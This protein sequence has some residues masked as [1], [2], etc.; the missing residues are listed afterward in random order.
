[1]YKTHLYA[2]FA[3]Y[4]KSAY[5]VKK[6]FIAFLGT[7]AGI[8]VSLFLIT[9]GVVIVV[10]VAGASALMGESKAAKI[11]SHSYLELKLEGEITERPGE[12][13]PIAIIQGERTATLGLNEIVG[14]IDAA[15][16]DSKIDAIAI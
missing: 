12:L 9:V 16:S 7:M 1:M 3:E 11:S 15:A 2:I 5:I 6:F 8:W 4:Y 13:D 10:A 14:A